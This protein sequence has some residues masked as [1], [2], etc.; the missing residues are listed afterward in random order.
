[1]TLISGYMDGSAFSKLYDDI[2]KVDSAIDDA[3][4]LFGENKPYETIR[5][6]DSELIIFNDH[7]IIEFIKMLGDEDLS[8]MSQSESS[9]AYDFIDYMNGKIAGEIV[10]STNEAMIQ[11]DKYL[12][13]EL[14]QL[15]HPTF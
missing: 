15:E 10:V 8:G 14:M 6:I 7:F 5:K 2:D 11:L 13:D 9:I 1:M 4:E 3:K 12:V